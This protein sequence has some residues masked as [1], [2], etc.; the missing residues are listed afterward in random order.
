MMTQLIEPDLIYNSFNDGISDLWPLFMQKK[1]DFVW[2]TELLR[3]FSF[4]R[5]RNCVLSGPKP[6]L[7]SMKLSENFTVH[8]SCDEL[9]VYRARKRQSN[10]HQNFFR[11][12]VLKCHETWRNEIKMGPKKFFFEQDFNT[13]VAFGVPKWK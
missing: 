6:Q 8:R 1:W 4:S 2:K 12:I 13:S 5:W 7:L 10:R 9:R 3:I 11:S